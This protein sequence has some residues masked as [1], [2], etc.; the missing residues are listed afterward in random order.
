M[1]WIRVTKT[2][3]NR[4]VYKLI[5]NNK[6]AGEMSFQLAQQSIRVYSEGEQRVFFVSRRRPRRSTVVIETE[7]GFKEAVIALN[8]TSR[9]EESGT[10]LFRGEVTDFSLN[11]NKPGTELV[12][13]DQNKTRPRL[14]CQFVMDAES[15]FTPIHMNWRFRDMSAALIWGV[16][17]YMQNTGAAEAVQ[18]ENLAALA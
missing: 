10:I 7:Y 12:M 4:Q 11:Y 6:L 16:Y 5:V 8:D 3:T 15:N 9:R 1:K 14:V 17:W 18:K 13:Y 2:E